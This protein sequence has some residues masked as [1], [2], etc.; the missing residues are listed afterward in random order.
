[1]AHPH[2]TLRVRLDDAQA[3][4]TCLGTPTPPYRLLRE[5][6]LSMIA[7]RRRWAYTLSISIDAVRAHALSSFLTPPWGGHRVPC[8][9]A[10]LLILARSVDVSPSRDVQGMTLGKGTKA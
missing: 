6:V 1:M 4:Y 9:H 10:Y 7:L 5:L 3:P 2:A 8:H